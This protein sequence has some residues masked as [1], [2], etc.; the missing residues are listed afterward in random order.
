MTS[1]ALL[2]ARI[3][4]ELTATEDAF[5]GWVLGLRPCDPLQGL[6][7]LRLLAQHDRGGRWSGTGPSI[8]V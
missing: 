3:L 2:V 4:K 8:Q 1:S 7:Q 6:H 5:Y